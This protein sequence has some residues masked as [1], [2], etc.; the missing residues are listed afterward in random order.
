MQKESLPKD[1]LALLYR[2]WPN[3]IYASMAF[4]SSFPLYR[5]RIQF[6]CGDKLSLINMLM[7]ASSKAFFDSLAKIH[8]NEYFL[9]P[10]SAFCEFVKEEDIHQVSH[11]LM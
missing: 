1:F 7:Y 4:A 10:S 8:T 11:L 6:Y 2:L 5:K 3:L 9:S